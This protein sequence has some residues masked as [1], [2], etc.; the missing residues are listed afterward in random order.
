MNKYKQCL[1]IALGLIKAYVV[2]TLEGTTQSILNRKVTIYQV[3]NEARISI[4]L[5]DLPQCMSATV[6]LIFSWF[7]QTFFN[8]HIIM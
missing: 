6:R 7:F 8:L 1:S 2:K 3:L 4:K 5:F